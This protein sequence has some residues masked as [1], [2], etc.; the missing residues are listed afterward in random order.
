MYNY[1]IEFVHYVAIVTSE[2]NNIT[3]FTCVFFKTR[4]NA[5][6]H[7][8]IRLNLTHISFINYLTLKKLVSL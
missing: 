7:L 1:K 6:Y 4:D 8:S 5:I 3:F 2:M